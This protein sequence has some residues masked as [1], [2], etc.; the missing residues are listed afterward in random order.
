MLD[1]GEENTGVER[2]VLE[3]FC[4][5][6]TFPHNCIFKVAASHYSHKVAIDSLSNLYKDTPVKG[7]SRKKYFVT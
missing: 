2:T 1:L 7:A 4:K 5:C 6:E 3:P